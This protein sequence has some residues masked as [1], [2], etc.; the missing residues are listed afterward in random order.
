MPENS[1]THV[2]LFSGI[3]PE[4]SA[5][6]ADGQD[7]VPLPSAKKTNGASPSC[8]SIGQTPQ[9]TG[10]YELFQETSTEE[11]RSLPEAYHASHL[12][13]AGSSRA[14]RMT[15]ISGLQCLRQSKQSGHLGL[16]LKMF[17][18]SSRWHSRLSLLTWKVRDFSVPCFCCQLMESVR[19]TG[20]EGLLLS[21]NHSIP[22]PTASDHIERKC[23]HTDKNKK[24]NYDTNKAVSLDRWFRN[25]FGKPLIPECSEWLMGYP[26]GWTK[27]SEEKESK[28]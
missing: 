12:L 14:K 26:I 8:D 21:P 15:D 19:H 6:P 5:L 16:F 23:T 17:L 3:P 7:S 9:S 4:D 24:L 10:I 27:K 25:R 18:T 28:H 20:D 2:D 1:L 22:T 13:N 11:P